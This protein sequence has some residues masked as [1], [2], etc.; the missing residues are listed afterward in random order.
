MQRTPNFLSKEV[1][2]NIERLE[3]IQPVFHALSTELRL[4]IIRCIAW[5]SKSVNELARELDMPVSTVALN[6]QV[7]EKAGLIVCD[8]QP[9]VRGTLKLCSRRID[10]IMIDLVKQGKS[11]IMISSEMPELLGMS[12]RVI[13]MCNGRITGELEGKDATQEKVMAFATKFDLSGAAS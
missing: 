11:I 6:V 3:E 8:T 1:A 12:N 4:K 10:Q 2:L 7:L 5:N 13:V 9:G